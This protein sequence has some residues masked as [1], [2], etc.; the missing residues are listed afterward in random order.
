[1]A[2]TERAFEEKWGWLPSAIPRYRR[3]R[4]GHAWHFCQNCPNWPV[5]DFEEAA[6][7]NDYGVD[8]LPVP[9][10]GA[11]CEECKSLRD[12]SECAFY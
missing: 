2:R 3:D 7:A 9:P 5:A 1:M 12:S 10:D 4:G 6:P 8:N 11:E